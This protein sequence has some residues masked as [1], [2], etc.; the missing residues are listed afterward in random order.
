MDNQLV[1]AGF[2]Y[3][4]NGNPVLYKGVGLQFDG[5]NRLV[6]YGGVLTA[7][8]NGDGLRAWKQTALGRRYFLYD[9]EDLVCELDTG[10]NVVASMVFGANGLA[11]YGLVSYQF[12][13]QGNVA[14][15]PE[16]R[17]VRAVHTSA[18]RA[19]VLWIEGQ[20]V[21]LFLLEKGWG[22]LS[23]PHGSGRAVCLLAV[24]HVHSENRVTLS[25]GI[26][27]HGCPLLGIPAT[28]SEAVLPSE[29]LPNR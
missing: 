26:P 27:R 4:G 17:V 21:S 18:K 29:R 12:D 20:N 23:D 13:P 1:G 16:H 24:G 8:Y 11:V 5:E 28:T 7:G 10:G 3:D 6:A 19:G 9:G 15:V 14:H 22:W 25:A 2:S